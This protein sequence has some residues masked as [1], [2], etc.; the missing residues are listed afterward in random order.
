MREV[1]R[2]VVTGM[3]VLSPVGNNVDSTWDSLLKG[4]SGVAAIDH[5]DTTGHATTIAALVKHFDP[6]LCA[7]KQEVRRLDNFILYAL[8]ATRQAVADSGLVFSEALSERTGV[9]IGSGIGGLPMIE[10]TVQLGTPRRV[11]P[12]FIPG[13]IINM[14]AGL[15]SQRYGLRG[16]NLSMVSAC[17]SGAHSIGFAAREIARGA[18]DVMLAGGAEKSSC[19]VGI[20][21]FSA[22]R[23]LSK[24]NDAPTEASRPWDRDRDGFVLGDGA[25]I[26]VLEE[27]SHAK[28]RGARI[29]AEIKG[30]GMSSDA[31]HMTAAEPEGRG[32]K[33]A[34]SCALQDASLA[35]DRVDYVNAHGTST[36]LA[37]PIEHAAVKAVLGGHSTRIAMSSTKSM[38]GHLLGAA[39]ALEAVVSVLSIRDNVA[40]PTINL[41]DPEPGCDL[42]LVPHCAQ[43]REINC[44]LSNSF[45]FGGT[46]ASLIFSAL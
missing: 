31:Y 24:R 34:M 30:F 27:Y 29:Y 46:N 9:Y 22:A 28:A 32:M 23:A 19:S 42:N 20:A 45:G 39:G 21:G 40:P 2:V 13:S 18:V 26:L 38:T 7:S 15:V 25:G 43:E 5:F 4:V 37:D 3:G 14:A 8:E 1:K 35:A 11:S 16:P 44:V 41:H 36:P 33:A 10:S 12:F 17:A 6:E